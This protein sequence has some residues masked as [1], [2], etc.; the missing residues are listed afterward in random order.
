MKKQRWQET[1][2]GE[3]IVDGTLHIFS[4]YFRYLENPQIREEFFMQEIDG[5]SSG[6]AKSKKWVKNLG[7]PKERWKGVLSNDSL[8][9]E[10]IQMDLTWWI[11]GN[12]PVMGLTKKEMARVRR[13]IVSFLLF[14][15]PVDGFNFGEFYERDTGKKYPASQL[16]DLKR[17]VVDV[18]KSGNGDISPR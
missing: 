5:A 10:Q 17:G 1:P 12:G 13:N 7:I 2:E 11:L 4:R 15:F 14:K 9:A 6:N 16:N 3:L 8:E 18:T